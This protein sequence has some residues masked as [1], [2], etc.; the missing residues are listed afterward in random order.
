MPWAVDRQLWHC[1]ADWFGSEWVPGR[2]AV[3]SK[4]RVDSL[5][6]EEGEET[7]LQDSRLFE[8]ERMHASPCCVKSIRVV[9]CDASSFEWKKVPSWTAN[10]SSHCCCSP[11]VVVAVVAS[12]FSSI[13]MVSVYKTENVKKWTK[14]KKMTTRLLVSTVLVWVAF[15]SLH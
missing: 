5:P 4:N 15:V 6:R 14:R 10:C 3:F 2:D 1:A 11:P 13:V 12:S 7:Q 9:P 8:A